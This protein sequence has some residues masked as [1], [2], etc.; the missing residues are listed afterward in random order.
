MVIT[1]QVGVETPVSV[2]DVPRH[3]VEMSQ[4]RGSYRGEAQKGAR[5]AACWRGADIKMDFLGGECRLKQL[6][7]SSI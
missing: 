6:E 5:A 7:N 4:G 1:E 3:E 2:S